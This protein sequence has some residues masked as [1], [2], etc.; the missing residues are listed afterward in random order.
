MGGDISKN[1]L[2]VTSDNILVCSKVVPYFGEVEILPDT[3]NSRVLL[4][5]KVISKNIPKHILAEAKTISEA[6]HP[7][8]LSVYGIKETSVQE[9]EIYF[10]SISYTLE[11]EIRQRRERNEPFTNQEI[12]S[13]L[14]QIV[15]GLAY[16]QDRNIAHGGINSQAILKTPDNKYKLVH[17]TLVGKYLPNRTTIERNM[18]ESEL[19]RFVPPEILPNL[20]LKPLAESNLFKEDTYALGVAL[21][22]ACLLGLTELTMANRMQLIQKDYFP[23]IFQLMERLIDLNEEDR[24]DSQILSLVTKDQG[25]LNQVN[26]GFNKRNPHELPYQVKILKLM[27]I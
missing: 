22:D 12:F 13:I 18:S 26:P 20:Q 17:P 14:D 24:V 19:F 9:Y 15:S 3:L 21:I 27:I 2:L 25:I 16:L 8:L 1:K 10:E 23:V 5:K 4:R 7:H 11:D 6:N